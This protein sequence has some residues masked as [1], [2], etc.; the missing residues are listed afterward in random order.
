MTLAAVCFAVNDIRL[1]DRPP[2]ILAPGDALVLVDAAGIC[3]TDLRIWQGRKTRGVALP[4]VLGHEIAGRLQ[5]G[6]TET[7]VIVLPT[8]T[9]GSCGVCRAGREHL[10]EQRSSLGYALDG[11]FAQLL[12]VPA[13]ARARNVL[14]RPAGVSPS[15]GAMVEP[16]ACC[17]LAQRLLGPRLDT[18]LLLLGAG[19][20]GLLHLL[21]ARRRGIEVIISEP[22]AARRERA[23]A[24]GAAMALD[25][26]VAPL[27]E[28]VRARG[29][30]L[31]VT[32]IITTPS[33]DALATSL[34]TVRRGGAVHLFA[35][36]D[37][38]APLDVRR[39]HNDDIAI[40]G[41]SG[42][43]LPDATA[44][45]ELIASGAIDVTGLI[46]HRFPLARITQAL[47][48]AEAKSGLK[49]QVEPQANG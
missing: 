23:L 7:P 21:L 38:P 2:P 34:V 5:D 37:D 31:P 27:Q 47:G 14:R 49:A 41:H 15:A 3:G 8:I 25:P 40:L 26:Q 12:Q 6:A 42:Y 17:L 22:H 35:G 36:Y 9:C 46:S 44:A 30:D 20:I 45:L 4:R 24:L 19:P 10:C 29:G 11:G 13:R 48:V 28:Q 43:D 1:V 16:L 18:P 33:A 39:V 32:V